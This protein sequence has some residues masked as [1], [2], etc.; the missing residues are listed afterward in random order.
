MPEAKGKFTRSS[1]FKK[2]T[3]AAV[4]PVG[5]MIAVSGNGHAG[6]SSHGQKSSACMKCSQDDFESLCAE[7]FCMNP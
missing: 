3:G 1:F 7:A 6:E 5:K 4:A 2:D